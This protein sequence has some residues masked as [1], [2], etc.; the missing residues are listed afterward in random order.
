MLALRAHILNSALLLLHHPCA[1]PT[2][3][4]PLFTAHKIS[5]VSANKAAAQ[6]R[7]ALWQFKNIL[8]LLHFAE[9]TH[10]T[11]NEL[12]LLRIFRCARVRTK[13]KPPKP[14]IVDFVSSHGLE[15]L[16]ADRFTAPEEADSLYSFPRES[17]KELIRPSSLVY[18]AVPKMGQGFLS[19]FLWI[20]IP[21]SFFAEQ[22]E[23]HVTLNFLRCGVN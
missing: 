7:Y 12:S 11:A 20:I 9:R 6:V 4:P 21:V 16:Q 19:D 5:V 17:N 23:L 14:T 15:D 3:I 10:P 18:V 2:H 8:K 22:F 1:L 13:L